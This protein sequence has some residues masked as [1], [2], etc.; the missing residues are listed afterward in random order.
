MKGVVFSLKNHSSVKNN[1]HIKIS[2][3]DVRYFLKRYGVIATF[4]C[5]LFVGVAVGS[6]YAQNSEKSLFDSL[7]FLFTTNFD[8]RLAQNMAETFCACFASDFIFLLTVFLLG[9]APWGICAMPFV[10][11]FRGFGTGLTA[12]YLIM[13]YSFKGVGFY[14][15]ILLPGTFLFCMALILLLTSAFYT[16]KRMF[17]FTISKYTP[18]SSLWQ[19]VKD[20]CSR[21][22]SVLIMT[23]CSAV[24]DAVLWTLFAEGF[25]F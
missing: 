25:N 6:I 2:L 22:M 12:G 5:L 23:F 1:R 8:V 7:D 21:S 19:D 13:T 11:F 24:L 10:V 14:L 16:S 20:F 17:L 9:L 15:L 18:K 3:S 4:V